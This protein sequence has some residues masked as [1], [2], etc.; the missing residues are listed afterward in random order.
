MAQLKL[1]SIRIRNWAKI[2]ESVIEFPDK[3]LVLVTGSNLA[4]GGKM[5]SIGSGKTSLGEAISRA[6]V[7]ISGR[8]S[9]LGD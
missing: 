1:K 7:G 9:K 4:S 5:D 6:L 8:S 2:K 3:G